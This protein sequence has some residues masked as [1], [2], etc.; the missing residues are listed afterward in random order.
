MRPAGLLLR[1]AALAAF[2]ATAAAQAPPA[3]APVVLA[4]IAAPAAPGA[5]PVVPVVPVQAVAPAAPAA[6]APVA[7]PAAVPPPAAP[8]TPAPAAPEAVVPPGAAPVAAAAAAPPPPPPPC[9]PLDALLKREYDSLFMLTRLVNLYTEQRTVLPTAPL[10]AS[11]GPVTVLAPREGAR[12]LPGA[13]GL[14]LRGLAAHPLQ[15]IL[16]APTLGAQ[17][18]LG[19]YP[20]TALPRAFLLLIEMRFIACLFCLIYIK[21]T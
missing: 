6:P 20:A 5:A 1:A 19:Y 18:V 11:F 12:V 8:T 3:P 10:N 7:A 14:D 9:P 13:A 2:L 4:P 21:F 17:F 16:L 15:A